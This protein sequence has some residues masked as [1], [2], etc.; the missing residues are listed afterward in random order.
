[1]ASVSQMAS[2]MDA[3]ELYEQA[4][5][6]AE[7]KM[8]EEEV[9]RQITLA[10]EDE[11]EAQGRA[12][13]ALDKLAA[14]G[15][16]HDKKLE[17]EGMNAWHGMTPKEGRRIF[18]AFAHIDK[19][20]SG[21]VT[22]AEFEEAMVTMGFEH[23]YVK[24]LFAAIDTDGTGHITYREF[25][26]SEVILN[27]CSKTNRLL[28]GAAHKA[29]DG[30]KA[31]GEARECVNE[32]LHSDKKKKYE[33]S[34]MAKVGVGHKDM[35]VTAEEVK[36]LM[37]QGIDV[38]ELIHELECHDSK[39]EVLQEMLMSIA[40]EKM[41]RHAKHLNNK[42]LNFTSMVK[43][44][45]FFDLDEDGRISEDEFQHA[46]TCLGLTVSEALVEKMFSIWDKQGDGLCYT[47][48]NAIMNSIG[49]GNWN[50]SNTGWKFK[51]IEQKHV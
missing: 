33:E 23:D 39:E 16:E 35:D 19:D 26:L 49:G 24:K 11:L 41:R 4:E 30:D 38:S 50:G 36:S 27:P 17:K 9:G 34:V 46:L 3:L 51:R 48:F 43:C 1:M 18:D 7:Q 8:L 14:P 12:A 32:K 5:K 25:M 21:S 40:K 20:N 45:Q 10:D 47:E 44:F 22:K 29:N 13:S 6:I 28:Q 37:D 31:G 2:A 42:Q 15:L